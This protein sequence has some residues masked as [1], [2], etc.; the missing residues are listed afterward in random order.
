MANRYIALRSESDVLNALPGSGIIE[1]WRDAMKSFGEGYIASPPTSGS[2]QYNDEHS[3][4]YYDGCEVFYQQYL[5]WTGVDNTY[6][7][8]CLTMSNHLWDEYVNVYGAIGETQVDPRYKTRSQWLFPQSAY[9]KSTSHL[10]DMCIWGS[11]SGYGDGHQDAYNDS[12]ARGMGYQ[13]DAYMTNKLVTGTDTTNFSRNQNEHLINLIEEY[14]RNLGPTDGKTKEIFFQLGILANAI[15]RHRY[16]LKRYFRPYQVVDRILEYIVSYV[17][18][19]NDYRL[20]YGTGFIDDGNEGNE[21]DVYYPGLEMVC[22][23]A[24]KWHNKYQQYADGMFEYAV[25]NVALNQPKD[26]VEHYRWSIE[27]ILDR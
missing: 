27:Y 22:V 15:M 14:S 9:R 8:S 6:A 4:L 25:N 11:Y 19:Q 7:S 12:D 21:A 18:P 5:Y 26:Y 20:R 3:V 10:A 16:A 13:L 24:F 17:E 2:S 1:D 23:P